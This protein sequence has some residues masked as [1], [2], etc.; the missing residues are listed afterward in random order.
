MYLR[1]L[2]L[3][4]LC[5]VS[6]DCYGQFGN[7]RPDIVGQQELN[8]NEDVSLTIELSHLIVIDRDDIYPDDFTLNVRAG[9][10]YTVA[11]TTITP[12]ANFNG[13]LSVPV[14]VNDGQINSRRYY[15]TVTV[16]PVNDP[17]Q[18][19]GQDDLT[20]PEDQTISISVGQLTVTDADDESFTLILSPGTNY[21]VSGNDVIPA[22]NFSGTLSVTTMVSDGEINSEPFSL[23]INVTPVNDPPV[24]TGQV[25]LQAIPGEPLTILPSHLTVSDPDNQYPGEF[26]VNFSPGENYSLAANI[27]TPDQDFQGTLAVIVTVSDGLLTSAPF[28]LTI[29]VSSAPVNGI[30]FISGQAPLEVNE[31]ESIMLELTDLEIK[32]LEEMENKDFSISI[33]KGINYTA[34]KNVITPDLNFNGDLTVSIALTDGTRTGNTFKLSIKVLPVNDPPEVE[35]AM[36]TITHE[37]GREPITF[38]GEIEISDIDSDTIYSAEIGFRPENYRSGNDSFLFKRYRKINGEFDTDAGILR[39]EGPASMEEYKTAIQSVQY[40]YTSNKKAVFE[41]K[42]VYLT[43]ND[44]KDSG[45]PAETKIKL[46]PIPLDIPTGFTPNGD[47]TNDR[48]RITPV[49]QTDSF[50]KSIIKVYDKRGVLVYQSV[51]L[52]SEWDGKFNNEL[53]PVDT[54]YYTIDLNLPTAKAV[55][56]GWV[57]ILQ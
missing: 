55:Y 29:Q 13:Y 16:I 42:T 33:F 48:W 15:L 49:Q 57:V 25:P 22:S 4:L 54:Y 17:P 35:L 6:A 31:D 50:S 18:I 11:G 32:G 53:L 45:I 36:E 56:N 41:T 39:L 46:E 44:G 20:I 7:D 19:T 38:I 47:H 40:S 26:T 2:M 9:D 14:T 51:G 30:P 10:N 21:T 23:Q 28:S 27:I 37:V 52:E 5:I 8:T 12:D 34:E 24:I 1:L 43:L 3:I